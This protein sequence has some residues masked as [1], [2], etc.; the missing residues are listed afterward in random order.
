MFKPKSVTEMWLVMNEEMTMIFWY[1]RH[2]VWDICSDGKFKSS[3][4]FIQLL[5]DKCLW[6]L[7]AVIGEDI[8]L[9]GTRLDFM[10]NNIL[11]NYYQSWLI[12]KLKENKLIQKSTVFLF[13][14]VINHKKT[15]GDNIITCASYYFAPIVLVLLTWLDTNFPYSCGDQHEKWLLRHIYMFPFLLFLYLPVVFPLLIQVNTEEAE[16][17]SQLPKS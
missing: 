3:T 11:V 6:I 7:V 10:N 15:N 16:T 8:L 12:M 14:F 13:H 17:P 9:S 2:W 1:Y 4:N 5:R